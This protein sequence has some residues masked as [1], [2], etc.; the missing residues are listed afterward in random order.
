MKRFLSRILTA[1]VI[2]LLGAPETMCQIEPEA[3]KAASLFNVGK[4]VRWSDKVDF[5]QGH[6]ICLPVNSP[7]LP[8]LRTQSNRKI[9]SRPVQLHTF[10][11]ND[12][13]EFLSTQTCHVIYVPDCPQD[14]TDT[15]EDFRD[16]GMITVSDTANATILQF[17]TE[18]S[19]IRMGMD[20]KIAERWNI[21]F[22]P[23]FLVLVKGHYH[24]RK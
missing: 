20:A 4:F 2:M 12:L 9:L 1:G 7:T 21:D 14:C 24:R 16:T 18:E 8:I 13:G 19:K 5:S 22:S 10:D 17:V 6:S 23:Q 11:P 3:V 15:L